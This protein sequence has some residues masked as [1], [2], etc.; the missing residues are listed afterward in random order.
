MEKVSVI[1][2]VYNSENQIEACL[3]SILKQTYTNIEIICINDGSLDNT[4][5]RLEEYSKKDSRIIIVNKENSGASTSR[6]IGIERSTGKYITFVDS[7]DTIEENMIEV[8]MNELAEKE[9][10]I[11]LCNFYYVTNNRIKNKAS[12]RKSFINRKE[13]LKKFHNYYTKTLINPPWNKI[14]IKDKIKHNFD[15]SL[16]LGEDL[17]FNIK[18]FNGIERVAIVDEYLY[19]YKI[20]N[21]C[22]ITSKFK[23]NP[24]EYFNMYLK[25]FNDLFYKNEVTTSLKFDLFFVKDYI[26]YFFN[27]SNNKKEI[28]NLYKPFYTEIHTRSLIDKLRKRIIFSR[29]TYLVILNIYFLIKK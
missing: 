29:L 11:V 1:I 26:S 14:Y 10:E 23:S 6:N 21:I 13:F 9:S 22:S 27:K 28:S 15:S 12:K 7:D 16:I 2:P 20:N 25:I 17:D 3:D 4:Q 19:N 8:L 5:N 24:N 18:Y